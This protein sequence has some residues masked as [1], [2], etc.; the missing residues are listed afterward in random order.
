[1]DEDVSQV[2]SRLYALPPQRFTAERS[3]AV[4]A[5]REAGDR[6][7]A[8]ELRKLRRPTV[9][10]WLVNLL[11]LRRPQL[12][13]DLAA[14]ADALQAAQRQLD[15]AQLRELAG[16]RR[17]TIAALVAEARSLALAAEPE[18][19]E[20]KLPLAEV[21][22]TLHAALGDPEVAEQ[23]RSGRLVRA[24]TPGGFGGPSP[25][26]LRL[27][28]EAPADER[29]DQAGGEGA[30]EAAAGQTAGDRAAADRRAARE[31]AERELGEARAAATAA[32]AELDRAAAEQQAAQQ[33]LAEID[34]ELAEL[35]ARRGTTAQRLTTAE[36]ESF[37]ARRAAAEA[38][39]R[40]TEAET[41]LAE[42][43]QDE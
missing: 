11:A 39:R 41:A 8:A 19:A 13:A 3:A 20:G 10:A 37:A 14:L 9:A 21:E 40:V 35:T 23:V 15:G 22:A 36:G 25:A 34:A 24:A 30:D 2:A 16:Q 18:L 5:A 28:G 17:A 43:P 1:M 6:A 31:A 27:V 32:S 38:R 7:G 4:A 42:L 33:E 26:K 12:V 29:A